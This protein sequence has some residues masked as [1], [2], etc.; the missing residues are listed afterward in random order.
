M[1]EKVDGMWGTTTYVGPLTWSC[2]IIGLWTI[3]G[4]CLILLFFPMDERDVYYSNGKLYTPNG[5]FYKSATNKNF[6]L[7]KSQHLQG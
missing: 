6:K 2:A 1:T 5:Y 4:A 7:R 3:I